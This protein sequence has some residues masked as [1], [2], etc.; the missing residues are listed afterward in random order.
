MGSA[1]KIESGRSISELIRGSGK[2]S[3]VVEIDP[4]IGEAWIVMS[5]KA[6]DTIEPDTHGRVIGTRGKEKVF[7][8]FPKIDPSVNLDELRLDPLILTRTRRL[9]E[10]NGFV[11]EQKRRII[12]PID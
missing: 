10:T 9:F 5:G 8:W 7:A 4:D 3:V 11:V 6:A 12:K 1:L 2:S